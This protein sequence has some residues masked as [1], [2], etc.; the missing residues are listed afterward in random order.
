VKRQVEIRNRHERRV[1]APPGPIAALVADF[2]CVWPVQIMPAPRRVGP[3]RYDT[4]LMVWEEFERPG[5]V[6]AFRVVRPDELQGEHW[7]ELVPDGS[8]T[9]VRHV[10][11]ATATGKYEAI[12]TERI[13]PRHDAVLEAL[14]D[15]VQAAAA[16]GPA[17]DS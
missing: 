14:L 9:V 12:W 5:A 4:G 15:N 16:G 13:E 10:I 1:A 3:G 17:A 11:E 8:A 7:F 6:R 2:D